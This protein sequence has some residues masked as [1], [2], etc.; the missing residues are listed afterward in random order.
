LRLIRERNTTPRLHLPLFPPKTHDPNYLHLR[1]HH[2]DLLLLSLKHPAPPFGTYT[3]YPHPPQTNKQTNKL[4]LPRPPTLI[5]SITYSLTHPRTSLATHSDLISKASRIHIA[6]APL[7]PS[8]TNTKLH[9]QHA[10]FPDRRAFRP[11]HWRRR[12]RHAVSI[13]GP[14]FFHGDPVLRCDRLRHLYRLPRQHHH[15]VKLPC[16]LHSRKHDINHFGY[17][18]YSRAL[19]PCRQHHRSRV[20]GCRAYRLCSFGQRTQPLQSP[21][22]RG[23]CLHSQ[24]QR[25][26]R[27]ACRWR[28]L[29]CP[30]RHCYEQPHPKPSASRIIDWCPSLIHIYPEAPWP[31]PL[32]ALFH[33]LSRACPFT[34]LH[35]TLLPSIYHFCILV[36]LPDNQLLI[37]DSYTLACHSQTWFPI[38]FYPITVKCLSVFPPI[39]S[40]V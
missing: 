33:V 10:L 18:P 30:L 12:R 4:V 22:F 25:F 16:R 27:R 40:F 14:V 20:N 7:P 23:R 32:T 3:P 13:S 19:L 37:F 24:R 29:P 9:R 6:I 34:S 39:H 38:L 8:F 31:R 2:H 15:H 5:R 26:R 11:R 28:W 21:F 17:A 35:H 1:A 36:H